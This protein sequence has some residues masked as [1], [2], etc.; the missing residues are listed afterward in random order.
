M[1]EDR[2]SATERTDPVDYYERKGQD[3]IITTPVVPEP[4]PPPDQPLPPVVLQD[5]QD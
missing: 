4:P 3:I 2:Q 1:A 5:V